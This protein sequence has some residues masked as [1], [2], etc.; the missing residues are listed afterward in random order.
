VSFASAT[1]TISSVTAGDLLTIGGVVFTAVNGGAVAANQQFNDTA[2]AG[3]D[4]ASALSLETTINDPASQALIAGLNSGTS[5]LS[6]LVNPGVDATGPMVATV[7]GVPGEL[8]LASS[9]LVTIVI[10][11]SKLVY[12]P[13]NGAP[14]IV[15]LVA[16]GAEPP[17]D[18][19]SWLRQNLYRNTL[20]DTNPQDIELQVMGLPDRNPPISEGDRAPFPSRGLLG[21]PQKDYTSV[22]PSSG[23]GEI[24]T[25]QRDYSS[26]T[27]IRSF[28][29]TFDVGFKRDTIPV[30][31][32]GQPF[33]HMRIDGLN[34]QD[35]AYSAPGPGGLAGPS[36]VSIQVKVPGVTAWMDL[37]R[38]DG[39]GPSKQDI[40]LDGAGCQIVGAETFD[41]VD[42]Q[43]G[44]V[45]CQ[46]KVN[47][48]P[49][50]NLFLA[51]AVS[52]R[53]TNSSGVESLFPL[54]YVPVLVKVEM[55]VSGAAYNLEEEYTGTPGGFAPGI[56]P[57]LPWSDVRG[58]VGISIVHP[59]DVV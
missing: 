27:G 23:A 20:E 43:T 38:R 25:A 42:P 34:L 51:S 10:S 28:V 46:V 6:A 26:A 50:I 37:G 21:Y 2:S 54:D 32:E 1:Y 19:S 22:R 55:D 18:T 52:H 29:R 16:G 57:G 35:F 48:G 44:S 41:S 17:W 47:V 5:A 45:Y 14:V 40:A 3:T 9:N 49:S 24:A 12:A 56:K 59:D 30:G 15:P 13:H 11:S 39:A 4:A 7:P 53:F 31:A 36:G 33:F 8:L 58:I